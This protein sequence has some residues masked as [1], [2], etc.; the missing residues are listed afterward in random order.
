MGVYVCK[1]GN[2]IHRKKASFFSMCESQKKR[3]RGQKT[4]ESFAKDLYIVND[5]TI[6][7]IFGPT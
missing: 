7:Y 5:C 4:E 1:I 6:P 2:V 3:E